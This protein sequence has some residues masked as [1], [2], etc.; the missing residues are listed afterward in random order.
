MSFL[1]MEE[2]DWRPSEGQAAIAVNHDGSVMAYVNTYEGVVTIHDKDVVS[3]VFG[4]IG[5]LSSPTS[6]CFVYRKGVQTILIGDSYN[7]YEIALDG[8]LIRRMFVGAAVYAVDFSSHTD[9]IAVTVPYEH[10]VQLMCYEYPNVAVRRIA[11][12]HLL[13]PKGIAFADRGETIVVADCGN[14]R[15][16]KFRVIDGQLVAHLAED[17]NCPIQV[18]VYGDDGVLVTITN[19]ACQ[20]VIV[21]IRSDGTKEVIA[22]WSSALYHCAIASAESMHGVVVTNS[23][24]NMPLMLLPE[25]WQRSSRRSWLSVCS[26]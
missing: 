16:S 21:F 5:E 4:T 18:V 23:A 15:V 22:T 20:E 6:A 9:V 14:D 1:K 10:H 8:H 12:E 2:L 11:A 3:G 26:C 7:I 17:M 13:F 24:T 25:A 19:T